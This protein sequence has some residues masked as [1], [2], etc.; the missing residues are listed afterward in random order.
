MAKEVEICE[1]CRRPIQEG[2]LHRQVHQVSCVVVTPEQVR[3]SD[4]MAETD[5]SIGRPK[6][7]GD[8]RTGR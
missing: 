4:V 8:D 6:V 2:T 3:R 1:H 5:L 7:D